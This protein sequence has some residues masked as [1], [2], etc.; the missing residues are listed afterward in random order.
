MTVNKTCL[1]VDDST[2]ICE[3]VIRILADVGLEAEGVATAEQA[4][5]FCKE[6]KPA[7]V[8]LDWDL[9]QLGALDFLRGAAAEL[10]PEAR[11]TIILCATENDHQQFTLARA[12]G[13]AHHILKPFDKQT[14]TAMLAEIGMI[15]GGDASGAAPSGAAAN[16]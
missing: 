14:V 11:P 4:V 15:D 10:D 3:I 13:A 16:G 1:I 5:E 12:A 9:P 6:K 8:F 2:V 7:A